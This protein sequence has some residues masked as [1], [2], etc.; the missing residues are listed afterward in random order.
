MLED[1]F[2]FVCYK[3]D[4]FLSLMQDTHLVFRIPDARENMEKSLQILVNIES[5]K[6]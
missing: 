5:A 1:R 4:I 2:N 6:L 3:Q